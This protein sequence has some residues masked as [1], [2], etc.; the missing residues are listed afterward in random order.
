MSENF[1]DLFEGD[2]KHFTEEDIKNW[3]DG[4]KG[5]L[6][7]QEDVLREEQ[8]KIDDIIAYINSIKSEIKLG[9]DELSIRGIDTD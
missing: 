2:V 4:K 6:A 1:K 5:E 9:E 8:K 7:E 3:L